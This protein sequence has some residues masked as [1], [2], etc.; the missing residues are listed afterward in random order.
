[1]GH[2]RNIKEIHENSYRLY[3]YQHVEVDSSLFV[4][5]RIRNEWIHQIVSKITLCVYFEQQ[6]LEN[7]AKKTW[8]NYSHVTYDFGYTTH[9]CWLL[10]RTTTAAVKC[11]HTP[12]KT[13]LQ[14]WVGGE[15]KRPDTGSFHTVTCGVKTPCKCQPLATRKPAP[16]S[17]D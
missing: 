9:P 1:M 11:S 17:M 15:T 12:R 16:Q 8:Y 10:W 3:H 5:E 6:F 7:P 2:K 13:N 14:L 4:S